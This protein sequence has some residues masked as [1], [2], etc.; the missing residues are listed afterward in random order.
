MFKFLLS[1]SVCVCDLLKEYPVIKGSNISLSVESAL[2][3][4]DNV[5]ISWDFDQCS[6]LTVGKVTGHSSKMGEYPG[7]TYVQ[8]EASPSYIENMYVCVGGRA[9]GHLFY[10]D[11]PIFAIDSSIKTPFII[12]LRVFVNPGWSTSILKLEC[13]TNCENLYLGSF[14]FKYTQIGKP[15]CF[16]QRE[17]FNVFWSIWDNSGKPLETLFPFE[18][19]QY[20][21]L[22]DETMQ[23]GYIVLHDETT[24]HAHTILSD[25]TTYTLWTYQYGR[26]SQSS[27]ENLFKEKLEICFYSDV[28][29]ASGI[30]LG[31]AQFRMSSNDTEGLVFFLI[32]LGM[33]FPILCITTLLL[34]CY[35][36][37]RHRQFAVS[38]IHHY[39]RIQLEEEMANRTT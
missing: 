36:L 19:V 31:Y 25:T 39:E 4:T 20:T 26:L 11:P 32:F 37:K 7:L 5:G 30:H 34:H 23:Q 16:G 3:V 8:I 21:V 22:N 2:L 29:T 33:I 1:S 15:A 35:R 38:L 14:A 28:D 6:N 9:I 18:L 17:Q 13:T 27:Q 10:Y 12:P 24:Q